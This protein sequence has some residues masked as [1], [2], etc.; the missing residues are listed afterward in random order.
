MD[1]KIS[2]SPP[3]E[4]REVEVG[5]ELVEAH[6]EGR[7]VRLLGRRQLAQQLL[8]DLR[9][10]HRLPMKVCLEGT[11]DLGRIWFFEGI[12]RVGVKTNRTSGGYKLKEFWERVFEAPSA[13]M[14]AP[15]RVNPGV[16]RAATYAYLCMYVYTVPL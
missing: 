8:R 14:V 15:S 9:L 16:L 2:A 1:P 10:R 7:H 6:D 13:A 4:A 11:G 5:V 3:S 12:P